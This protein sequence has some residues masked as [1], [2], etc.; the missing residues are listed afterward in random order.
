MKGGT[1]TGSGNVTVKENSIGI[2]G[3]QMTGGSITHLGVGNVMTLE[4]NAIGFMEQEHL[5]IWKQNLQ[6]E[7]QEEMEQSPSMV[8]E[9]I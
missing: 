8:R 5:E 3:D 1:Y 2:Y 4:D 7:L 6:V 9:L